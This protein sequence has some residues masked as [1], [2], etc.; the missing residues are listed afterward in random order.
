M[1]VYSRRVKKH[2]KRIG[3]GKIVNKKKEIEK[4]KKN[5]KKSHWKMWLFGGVALLVAGFVCLVMHSLD[6]DDRED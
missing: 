2:N 5:S 3:K 6:H 1:S 4:M